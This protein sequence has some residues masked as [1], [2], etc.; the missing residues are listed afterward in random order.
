VP[1]SYVD[2]DDPIHL[3]FEYVRRLAAVADTAA[4]PGVPLKVLHLGGGALT[5]P[6]YLAATRPGSAQRVFERDAAL[7]ALIAR[8][9][10]L[11][12]SS[13]IQVEIVDARAGLAAT[14][15]RYDLILGDVYEGARMPRS[16]ASREFVALV[17]DRLA[18]GGLYA[19]NVADLPPLAF[20]RKQVATL[21][22]GF[23]EVCL[24]A[25]PNLLRGRRYGNL[26]LVA[27]PEPGA[28]PIDQL[29][30]AALRDPFPSRL[31]HGPPLDR[32]VGGARPV[33]DATAEGSPTPPPPLLD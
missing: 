6:R 8:E 18:P 21:R 13:G 16:V 26:V 4:P 2:L 9:L 23:G 28:L 15:R 20:T 22:T 31:L 14:D 24:I 29:V 12:R 30:R 10:P 17:A 1:Q 27:T 7:A 19:V 11:R 3:E 32:F 5:L 33:T 25:A